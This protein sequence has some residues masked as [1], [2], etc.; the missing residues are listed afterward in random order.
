MSPEHSRLCVDAM[1]LS[2]HLTRSWDPSSR[3]GVTECGEPFHWHPQNL[4]SGRDIEG[5]YESTR[6]IG[7]LRSYPETKFGEFVADRHGHACKRCT[8]VWMQV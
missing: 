5:E 8:K 2:V 6:R 4:H 7:G 1:T 3:S